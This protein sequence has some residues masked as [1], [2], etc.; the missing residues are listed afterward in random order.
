MTP[1]LRIEGGAD[2]VPLNLVGAAGAAPVSAPDGLTLPLLA[3]ISTVQRP[4]SVPGIDSGRASTVG[5]RRGRGGGRVPRVGAGGPPMRRPATVYMGA[6]PIFAGIV[7]AIEAGPEL[8]LS[9]EAGMDRPLSDSLPLRTNAVWG[10]WRE[11][12]VLPWG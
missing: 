8:R 6:A 2:G 1:W 12:R 11:V 7:T 10:G 3:A 5:G 4:L 9:L